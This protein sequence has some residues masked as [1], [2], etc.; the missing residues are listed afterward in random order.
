MLI[1]R[2]ADVNVADKE[3][4]T[5]LHDLC[6]AV[7][8]RTTFEHEVS[9]EM[10]RVLILAG[11]DTQVRDSQGHLPMEI[12]QAEDSQS[13]AIYEEAMVE[14]DSGALKPVLK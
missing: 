14:M 7:N 6:S 9:P 4:C 11:A 3:G 1:D 2:G 12:L 5:P 13:R 10:I 8:I